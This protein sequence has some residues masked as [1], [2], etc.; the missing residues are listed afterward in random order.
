[1]I[2][3]VDRHS[4]QVWYIRNQLIDEYGLDEV[5]KRMGKWEGPDYSNRK[6]DYCCLTGKFYED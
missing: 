6:I 3:S 2:T 1:M 4:I 5:E